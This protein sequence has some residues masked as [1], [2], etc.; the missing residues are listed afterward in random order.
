MR[1]MGITQTKNS[2]MMDN[3]DLNDR[4]FLMFAMNSY[5]NTQ[6]SGLDEFNED[7]ATTVHLKKLFTRYYLNGILKERLIV[8]HIIS[9]FNCFEPNAAARILFYRLEPV[10][11]VYLKTFLVFLNRCPD[12]TVINGRVLNIREIPIDLV[13]YNK[14]KEGIM[15]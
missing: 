15:R 13:L 4:N 1:N 7:L 8:N 10:H 9:F 3:A 14:I 12:E 2:T 5:S 11:H 6:C